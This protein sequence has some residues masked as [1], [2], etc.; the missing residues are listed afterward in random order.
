[1]VSAISAIHTRVSQLRTLFT[2]ATSVGLR[3]F[4][5]DDKR[6]RLEIWKEVSKMLGWSITFF[7]IAIIAGLLGFTGIAGAAVCIAMILFFLF[8]VLFV[9]FLIFGRRSAPPLYC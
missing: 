5:Q 2:A 1:M 6:N 7:V 4:R 9:L 8:F 3:V